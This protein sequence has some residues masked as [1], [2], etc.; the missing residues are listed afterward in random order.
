MHATVNKLVIVA[1]LAFLTGCASVPMAPKEQDAASKS[2]KAPAAKMSGV[3]IYRNSSQGSALKKTVKIDN[4]VIG[5]TARY[6]Y[7]HARSH[8]VHIRWQPNPNSATTSSTSPPKKARTTTF[9]NT[10]S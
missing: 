2:F 9:T 5:E 4:T 10:S 6:T 8:P 3:Y 1:T 7:F